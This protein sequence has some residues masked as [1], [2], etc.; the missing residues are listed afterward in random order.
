MGE[1]RLSKNRELYKF[2]SI[3]KGITK[4]DSNAQ[5][6]HI[7]GKE[8]ALLRT[9]LENAPQGKKP[10]R[11]VKLKYEDKVKDVEKVGLGMN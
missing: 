7:W 4:K 11:R 6:G 10:L 1:W 9:V 5:S 8:G 2:L 3:E